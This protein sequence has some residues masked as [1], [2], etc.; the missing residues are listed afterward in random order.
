[1]DLWVRDDPLIF[2]L[3]RLFL[4]LEVDHVAGGPLHPLG[5]IFL[6]LFDFFNFFIIF[7]VD[8]LVLLVAPHPVARHLALELVHG[9][10]RIILLY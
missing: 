10:L 7:E 5:N 9:V 3:D 6:E 2:L 1:V 8:K 4:E